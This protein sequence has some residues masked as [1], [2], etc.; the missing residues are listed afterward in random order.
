METVVTGGMD[1]A[2]EAGHLP[3]QGKGLSKVSGALRLQ[4][5]QHVGGM[6]MVLQ[7]LL[8]LLSAFLFIA[9]YCLAEQERDFYSKSLERTRIR[10]RENAWNVF[11]SVCCVVRFSVGLQKRKVHRQTSPIQTRRGFEE[12]RRGASLLRREPFIGDSGVSTR[13]PHEGAHGASLQ[14]EPL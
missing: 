13:L 10:N 14:V 8:L 2:N 1:R 11:P 3:L 6:Y 9:S 12:H 7:L 5:R 4:D